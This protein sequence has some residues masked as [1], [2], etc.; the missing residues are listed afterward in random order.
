V[1]P[2]HVVQSARHPPDCPARR[3]PGKRLIYR[4]PRTKIHEV[5]WRE[6]PAILARLDAQKH[7]SINWICDFHPESIVRNMYAYF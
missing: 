6:H 2:G 4:I 3:H 5:D 1:L 7:R